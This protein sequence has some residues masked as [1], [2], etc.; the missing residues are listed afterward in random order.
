MKTFKLM[1]TKLANNQ[2]EE[3]LRWV[4]P[5]IRRE[6]TLM[7]A[8]ILFYGGKRTLERWVSNYRK[9]GE[10]GLIPK[11]TKPKTN[12]NETPIRVK[13]DILEM[14]KDTNLCALKIKYRL[15]KKVSLPSIKTINKIIKKEGLVRKYRTRKIQCAYV[16]V[17]P[18]LGDLVEIDVKY[19]PGRLNGVR[20]YQFTAIDCFSRWRYLKVYDDISSYSAL[21]FLKEV[22][23]VAHFKIKAIKTDNGTCFTNRYV[24]YAKSKDPLNPKLHTLD[25]FCMKYN[26][27]H[28]LIDPGKPAQNGKVERSH[29]TDQE[30]FYDVNRFKNISEL[31]SKIKIWNDYY[32]NLEHISLKGKTPNETVLESLNKYNSK[33]PYVCS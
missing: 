17:M 30:H 28:Y 14:R 19:V 26:I 33:P 9:Y 3:R 4:L 12:P 32:N 23:K 22:I 15:G 29:R 21:Q 16:K 20:Y 18:S 2:L 31:D 24:G 8:S 7:D 11:S 13:E 1:C 27:I 10:A 25:L 6:V 5:I